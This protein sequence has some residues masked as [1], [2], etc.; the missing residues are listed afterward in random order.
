MQNY[1]L[2]MN[3][4]GIKTGLRNLRI[5]INPVLIALVLVCSLLGSTIAA[6]RHLATPIM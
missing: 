1:S 2:L 3:K 6:L 4:S 5:R